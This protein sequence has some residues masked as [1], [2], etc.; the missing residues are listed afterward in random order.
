MKKSFLLGLMMLAIWCHNAMAL[1]PLQESRFW[2][3]VSTR[4]WLTLEAGWQLPLLE[5]DSASGFLLTSLR[6]PLLMWSL[7]G[8]LDSLELNVAW[9][10]ET[11]NISL[12]NAPLVLGVQAGLVCG[13]HHQNLGFFLPIGTEIKANATLGLGSFEVSI[14]LSWTATWV[15]WYSPSVW[16][17]STFEGLGQQSAPKPGFV[18]WDSHQLRLGGEFAYKFENAGRFSV[19]L[20]WQ[21]WPTSLIGGFDGMAVGEWP[22]WGEFAWRF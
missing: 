15:S 14:P 16:V 20:G 11:K 2:L 10:Q 21:G 12:G 3:L 9:R 18:A 5:Q 7:G 19:G 8:G 4:S 6:M 22:F 13:L 1:Q 17:T